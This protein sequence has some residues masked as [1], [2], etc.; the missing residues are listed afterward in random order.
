[1]ADRAIISLPHP[2]ASPV[3]SSAVLTMK[4]SA[5]STRIAEQDKHSFEVESQNAQRTQKYRTVSGIGV[6]HGSMGQWVPR[7]Q[8]CNSR[9][10]FLT[11]KLPRG[12]CSHEQY[13]DFAGV[14]C[15]S[16]QDLML[17]WACR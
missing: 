14:D 5:D 12:G 17:Q 10:R 9:S 8:A 4:F 13:E 2:S 7:D 1:V 3:Q 16:F 6:I 11:A 15:A